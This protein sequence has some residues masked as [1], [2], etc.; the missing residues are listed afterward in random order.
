MAFDVDVQSVSIAT[1]TCMLLADIIRNGE[2]LLSWSQLQ[3]YPE[4]QRLSL[5]VVGGVVPQQLGDT[6]VLQVA[7]EM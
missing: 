5:G 7:P 6:D 4:T 1:S 3:L 2:S